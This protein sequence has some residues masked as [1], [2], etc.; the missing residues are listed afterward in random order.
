MPITW[1][2]ATS[3]P[4]RATGQT[5]TTGA[6]VGA[7]PK[8]EGPP[9]NVLQMFWLT[10]SDPDAE[11]HDRANPTEWPTGTLWTVPTSLL[12]Q[13]FIP[14]RRNDPAAYANIK[15]E[16]ERRHFYATVTCKKR[17]GHISDDWV[18]IGLTGQRPSAT[19]E[20]KFLDG[21]AKEVS[22]PLR[23]L[24][25][26]LDGIEQSSMLTIT[27]HEHGLLRSSVDATASAPYSFDAK[28]TVT[29][30]QGTYIVDFGV[31]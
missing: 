22:A 20:F 10:I 14:A 11:A 24:W 15:G 21:E 2:P 29:L 4:M 17:A 19:N 6:G 27:L 28:R 26:D 16:L 12:L 13:F 31:S 18:D 23:S 3:K 8:L 9:A 1:D 7:P 30:G 5:V 25:P